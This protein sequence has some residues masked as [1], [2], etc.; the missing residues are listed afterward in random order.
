MI[1][2]HNIIQNVKEIWYEWTGAN[3]YKK[4]KEEK[5]KLEKEK[6][7]RL[8]K[9]PPRQK[10][11]FKKINR[12]RERDINT[13]NGKLNSNSGSLRNNAKHKSITII[14]DNGDNLTNNQ[15]IKDSTIIVNNNNDNNDDNNRILFNANGNI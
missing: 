8:M 12:D 6:Q 10:D 1:K 14:N 4:L 15:Y 5:L 2:Y 11:E 9:K 7:E 13:A 3:K